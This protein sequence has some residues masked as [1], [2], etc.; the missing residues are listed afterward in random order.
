MPSDIII[1]G[2]NVGKRFQVFHSRL[3]TLKH[4]FSPSS[5]HTDEVWAL[6]GLNFELRRGEGIGLVGRNGSGKTTLLQMLCGITM[7]TEGRITINGSIA[8]ILALGSVFDTDLP[9]SENARL[10]CAV[11]GLSRRQTLERMD[12]I[13]DF[14]SI[15]DY[16]EQPV[17]T[18]SSGMMARLAYAICVQAEADILILDE[19]FA[20]GDGAF[21]TKCIAHIRK[22][23]ERGGTLVFVTH[24]LGIMSEFCDRALWIDRGTLR[25]TGNVSD[26]VAEYAIALRDE[27]EHE[28]R[29]MEAAEF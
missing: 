22:F 21:M 15:G 25:K 5:A 20:V 1:S 12:A 8:P 6:R 28:R 13:R 9:G 4:I 14:A 7:P 18:Y 27:P 3:D 16:F 2:E 24:G 10:G 26:V 11:L 23:R 19:A 29:F 17:R